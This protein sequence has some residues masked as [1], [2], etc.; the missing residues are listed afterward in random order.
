MSI[1]TPTP[2]SNGARRG[3]SRTRSILEAS[4]PQRALKSFDNLVALANDQEALRDAAKKLVWRDRGEPVTHINSLEDCLT[5]AIK[6]GARAGSLA[7]GLRSGVNIFILLFRV[8]KSPKELRFAIVRHAIFG[9]DSLRFGAMIGSFVALY[10]FLYNAIPLV[11]ASTPSSPLALDNAPVLPLHSHEPRSHLRPLEPVHESRRQTDDEPLDGVN[12]PGA[13]SA[14]AL[15]HQLWVRK[16]GRRSHAFIAGA[17]AGAIAIM[18]ERRNQR[19]GIAQQ[20]F[21]RGLQGS[22]N[23]RAQKHGIKIPH[24]DVIVFTLA[25]AQIMYAFT[26]RPDTIDRGYNVWIS[27]ASKVHLTAIQANRTLTR[28]QALDP[29]DIQAI[30]GGKERIISPTNRSFLL[31]LI[32]I[33]QNNPSQLPHH[34]PCE[35]IHP[36]I[37]ASNGF[38]NW[39]CFIVQLERFVEVFTWMF[40][41]YGALHLIPVILFKRNVFFKKPAPIIGQSLLNTIRSSTF[42]GVFVIIYQAALCWKINMYELL[43][44]PQRRPF[45]VPQWLLRVLVSRP[46]FWVLGAMSGLSLFVEAKRRRGELAMYVLPKALEVYWTTSMGHLGILDMFKGSEALFTAIGTGMFMSIYQNSPEHL[47][48]YARRIM[49]QLMGPN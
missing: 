36:W 24:G 19:V 37:D 16:K 49:Y 47:S 2:S 28:D 8:F 30:L 1:P 23:Y 33:A 18:F 34:G 45:P 22:Y 10:K 21:V 48:G 43:S 3:L 12:T 6:G 15:E 9:E 31:S 40:P 14:T 46:S 29:N 11:S 17:V 20:I 5:H 4:A 25:C 7:F 27:R 41:I 39:G 26:M 38:S 13:L 35:M 42:L 32:D 44:S